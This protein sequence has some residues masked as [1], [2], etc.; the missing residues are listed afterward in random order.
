MTGVRFKDWETFLRYVGSQEKMKHKEEWRKAVELWDMDDL[1]P[2][3]WKG[4]EKILSPSNY[5]EL[6]MRLGTVEVR[7]FRLP[8]ESDGMI[9]YAAGKEE[10]DGGYFCMGYGF[11]EENETNPSK[12][13]YVPLPVRKEGEKASFY[14]IGTEQEYW[15]YYAKLSERVP[16]KVLAQ[17]LLKA[18]ILDNYYGTERDI[19]KDMG[20]FCMIIPELEERANVYQ[21]LFKKYGLQ[22]ELYEYRDIIVGEEKDWI[23][24][25]FLVGTEYGIVIFCPKGLTEVEA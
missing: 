21:E 10:G 1:E 12:S 18:E 11:V 3:E 14:K 20:G 6:A 2:R 24:E 19:E 9:F 25:L 4:M 22:E 23:E 13:R 17:V 16:G 7:S 8:F 5:E 15:S